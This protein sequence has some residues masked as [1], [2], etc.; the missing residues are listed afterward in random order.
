MYLY[1]LYRFKMRYSNLDHQLYVER[2]SDKYRGFSYTK[3][4]D[5]KAVTYKSTTPI[6]SVRVYEVRQDGI[7]IAS[8]KTQKE[9]K[10]IIKA[11]AQ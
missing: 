6:R 3:V 5:P 11:R 8:V 10:A 4:L 9:A 2:E 1:R 7:L